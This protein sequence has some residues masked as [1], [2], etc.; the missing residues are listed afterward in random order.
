LVFPA[1]SGEPQSPRQLSGDWREVREAAGVP[2]HA[3]RHTH[4]SQLI[5]ARM[6]VVEISK[7]LGHADPAITLRIYVQ[8]EIGSRKASEVS[9]QIRLPFRSEVL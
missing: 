7:R 6:D 4:A 1:L 3:L 5:A 8:F 2:W 9:S